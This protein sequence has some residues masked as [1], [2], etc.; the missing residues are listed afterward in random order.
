MSRRLL[1][2]VAVSPLSLVAPAHAETVISTSVTT[3]VATSTAASGSRDDVR[4]TSA[5]TVQPAG[6]AAIRLDSDNAVTIEGAVKIQNADDA[7][8]LLVA[9][10]SRGEVKLSGAISID[11]STEPKDSDGDGDLD[12]PLATGAR[13]YGVRVI[14]PDAFHGS[15]VQTAGSITVEGRD[16]A[17]VS[18]ETALDG[19]LRLGGGVRVVG[20]RSYG[21]RTAGSVGGDVTLTGEVSVAGEGAV[22]VALDGDVAG[23]LT[24][25]GAVTA[26]GFRSTSRPGDA[27][28]AKLDADDLLIGGPAVRVQGDVGG[29]I[30]IDA[31]PADNDPKDDDEDDDGVADSA[32]TAGAI[33]VYGSAPALLIGGAQDVRIGAAGAGADA[34]GL[35]VK[36]AIQA[37]GVYDG[38]AAEAVKIG[39]EGGA[40]ILDGGVKVTGTVRSEAVQASATGFHLGAG[41]QVP[42]LVNSGGVSAKATGSGAS[43]AIALKVDAGAALSSLANSGT[44]AASFSGAKGSAAA[45]VDASG[46]LRAV[47]NTG[48]ISATVVPPQGEAAAGRAVALDLRANTAGVTLRQTQGADPKA[49][50][51]IVGDVLFGSGAA[52]LDLL[53]GSLDG[54]VAFGAGADTLVIDGGARMTGALSD[55][56]GGLSVDVGQGALKLTNSGAVNLTAL[57][58]GARSELTVSLDPAA[59]TGARLVVAGPATVEAGA[60]IGLAF[61]SKLTAPQSFTLIHAGSLAAAGAGQIELGATPWFYTAS[62]KVDQAAGDVVADVRRRTATEAGLGTA[63]A[64]AFD[65]V[66]EAFD[67]DADVRDALLAKTDEAGFRAL[68]DQFLPDYSGGLFQVLAAGAEAAGRAVDE[69]PTRLPPGGLRVW[70]QEIA[71]IVR[72]DIGRPGGYQAAG[73]GLTGGVEAPDTA[74]G[75]IGLQTSFLNADVDEKGS[76]AGET[77]DA[78]VLSAGVYWRE[79]VGEL[80]AALSVSGGYVD[81]SSTRAVVDE[82]AGLSR[83]AEAD[84]SGASL[85]AHAGLRYTFRAGAFYARPQ[86]ALDYLRLKEDAR[87]ETGGGEAVDLDI[88]SRDGAQLATFVGAAFG[89]RAGQEAD[90]SWSPEV[91]LGWRQVT[92]DGP[93]RTVS[94][95][96][97]GGPDFGLDAPELD[98]GA[99]VARLALRGEGLWY[100]IGLEAGGEARDGYQAYDARFT[101]R[102]VF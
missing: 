40:T 13:R 31:P 73:F 102:F 96:V 98:G 30:L 18:V 28:L 55:A 66:F 22:G 88:D 41:A 70:T 54:D 45:V 51:A 39:G 32:E 17:G 91:T 57:R 95:F 43:D 69:E 37:A 97:S 6:G 59:K 72:R 8:G 1:L 53:A 80:T 46:A 7:T 62:L 68:Y 19:A 76:A 101:A 74:L 35:V 50:P 15:I 47:D 25:G 27:A 99:G 71:F 90:F 49:A 94:R 100:D 85:T 64:S 84:W 81:L 61:Q 65:A 36:G 29:G 58:L 60:K 78:T 4:V 93:G 82:A 75:S 63:E 3:P 14:G 38:V 86:A 48:V 87:R 26:T 89:W 21:V 12:G 2:L 42:T 79:T 67:R 83:E 20:D 77:L 56:G 16:S 92:G 24:I 11:E 5:G 52:R 9:G 44:I 34:Y 23:R 33:S 10:G